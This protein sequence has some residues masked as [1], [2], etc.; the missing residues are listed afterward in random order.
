M[1][2]VT[3]TVETADLNKINNFFTQFENEFEAVKPVEEE[4]AEEGGNE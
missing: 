4:T 3:K 2:F 1:L